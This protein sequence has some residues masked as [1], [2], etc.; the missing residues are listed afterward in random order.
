MT[1]IVNVAVPEPTLPAT[2]SAVALSVWSP[3]AKEYAGPVTSAHVVEAT[4]DP[5]DGSLA[6]Q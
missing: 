6:E 1:T 5:G 4:P 2:S 3:S